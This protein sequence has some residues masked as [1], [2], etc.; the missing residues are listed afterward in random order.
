[1]KNIYLLIAICLITTTSKAQWIQKGANIEGVAAYDFF[2]EGTTISSD[3]NTIAIG[4]PGNDGTATAA[5]HV[6]VYEWSGTS[7]TQKGADIDGDTAED[8]SGTSVSMSS[9][10]STIAIGSS[11]YPATS[12]STGHVR[13]YEWSGT[14][15]TQ[16]GADINGE[17]LGDIFGGSTS[18]SY[19]GN[20]LAVG[21]P[22]N[23]G[24]TGNINDNRGHV[25]VYEW[26]GS[27][28]EQLGNDIDG[29][30]S[31]DRSGS[32]SLSS[33]GYTV[34]IG[35]D[36]NDDAGS[37]AG[38][39]RIFEWSG[40]SWNQKGV[41]IEGVTAG[42]L[43]AAVSLNSD[44]NIVAIGAPGNI[45]GYVHIYQ[46]SGS[47]WY[48]KGIINGDSLSDNMGSSV[49]LSSDG[50]T[51]LI[52]D[53]NSSFIGTAQGQARVYEFSSLGII[54]NDFGKKLLC[55]PNPNDGNFSV[56]LGLNYES[57][58]VILTDLN[59]KLIQSNSYSNSQ[60]LNL[61]LGTHA[62]VYLLTVKSGNKQA[63]ICLIT[64]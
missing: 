4:A 56:D 30:T 12:G 59:G 11:G 47:S 14:S 51:I 33:D 18:I 17:M 53:V 37:N 24:S 52:G 62:G 20:I 16:K 58:N 50:N 13:V 32:V 36:G 26:I 60:L 39:V 23:D 9:D 38:H 27:S 57:I 3:G 1:M 29:E 45:P 34:A 43:S 49:A 8:W 22:H 21:A 7:W 42:D 41:N 5:G 31:E 61:K 28:W 25:R 63:T 2:G 19:D 44:G 55:Y 10:G 54:K 6:R 35:G 15:W 46:W 40:T 64:E 48:Q